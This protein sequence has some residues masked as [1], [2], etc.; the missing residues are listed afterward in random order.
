[1]KCADV[2]ARESIVMKRVK[3]VIIRGLKALLYVQVCFTSKRAESENS[4]PN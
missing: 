1:M 4:W 2:C 3:R